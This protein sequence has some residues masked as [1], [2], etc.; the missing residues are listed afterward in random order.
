[1]DEIMASKAW[2]RPVNFAIVITFDEDEHGH[3][4]GP[5]CCGS[6]QDSAANFGGGHI[7]TIV[8]TNNGPRHFKDATP[9]NHYSLLR[10]TE[11]A[12]GIKEYLGF[13]GADAKGVT[14][15]TPLFAIESKSVSTAVTPAK[16]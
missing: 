2:S 1:V 9:Y 11:E 7:P 12:F 6:D 10:T 5:G 15:M 8:I 3:A 16:P 14:A 4:R 13:A